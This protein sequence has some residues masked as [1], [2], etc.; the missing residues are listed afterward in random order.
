MLLLSAAVRLKPCSWS[1][2]TEH[3]VK[4]QAEILVLSAPF[5]ECFSKS[6][7]VMGR[8]CYTHHKGSCCVQDQGFVLFRF[9]EIQNLFVALMKIVQIC[10]I[11]CLGIAFASRFP[12]SGGFSAGARQVNLGTGV[13]NWRCQELVCLPACVDVW[14][15]AFL[16]PASLA[17]LLETQPGRVLAGK[18]GKS[19][20][21]TCAFRGCQR[22]SL[23]SGFC[24]HLSVESF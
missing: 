17:G 5:P 11:C 19:V 7:A 16:F 23:I 22:M 14:V 18:L 6:D 13:S 4:F 20:R 12:F 8:D 10:K 9:W 24:A 21:D 2:E 1:S 3:L 15:S